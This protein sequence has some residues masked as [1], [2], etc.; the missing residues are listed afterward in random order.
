M[1]YITLALR[2]IAIGV[3]TFK[4]IPDMLI[5]YLNEKNGLKRLRLFLLCL[6]IAST[7]STIIPF[8]LQTCRIMDFCSVYY[9]N[10]IDQVGFLS[11]VNSMIVM[12]LFYLIYTK[13]Y[14]Y[15]LFMKH[16]FVLFKP[17]SA[18]NYG[19]SVVN[20]NLFHK[21]PAD[22]I[23]ASKPVKDVPTKEECELWKKELI[24]AS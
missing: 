19:Y 10:V 3:M 17:D 6:G 18:D 2:L 15:N 12:T 16:Y 13:R 8:L 22:I 11:S 21:I 23:H 7:V 1:I 20:A 9:S 4:I 24:N 14:W 5:L